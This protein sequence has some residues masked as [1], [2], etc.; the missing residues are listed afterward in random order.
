MHSPA[1]WLARTIPA[2]E[3]SIERRHEMFTQAVPDRRYVV[4]FGNF[5]FYGLP[6]NPTHFTHF[7][8]SR[9]DEARSR[10]TTG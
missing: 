10:C 5:T 6:G 1:N 4:D 9:Y 2:T 8:M 3:L 7:D